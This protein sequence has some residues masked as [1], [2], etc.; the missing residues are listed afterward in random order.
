MAR[1]AGPLPLPT[2]HFY[3]PPWGPVGALPGATCPPP[4]ATDRPG[5]MSWVAIPLSDL[6]HYDASPGE[7]ESREELDL[8]LRAGSLA[9]LTIEGLRL[10]LNPPDLTGVD[11]SD[12]LFVGCRFPDIESAA[13]VV[14]RGA[15]VVPIFEET[16]YPTTPA[17]LYTP[18][19]LAAG[20]GGADQRGTGGGADQHGTG[21]GADQHGTGGG[22]D[23][24]GTGGGAD[25]HGT[26]TTGGYRAM[27][28]GVV[29]AH[30]LAHGGPL[31]DVREALAQRLHDAGID[32]A[33][34]NA[35]TAGSPS[36]APRVIGI[37]GGHAEPRGGPTY[38]L[39]AA[40]AQRLA[41]PAGWSSPVAGRA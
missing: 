6:G 16:P 3:W 25:Q 28:D 24:H 22:A 41:A 12:A 19:D 2:C 27:Y 31:P 18:D 13:D 35:A 34:I 9:G 15:S 29:H 7:I 30:F 37:M 21:G 14:R 32:R 8:H 36:T 4:P 5:I 1:S 20:F 23:Q 39:A 11:V 38:R 40:L 17:R 33:L 10:D 26:G